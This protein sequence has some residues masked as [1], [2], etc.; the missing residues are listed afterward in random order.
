MSRASGKRTDQTQKMINESSEDKIDQIQKNNDE[1]IGRGIRELT[2]AK[3]V[4]F[5]WM[6]CDRWER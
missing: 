1:W 6:E 5:Y 2:E 3:K 4:N